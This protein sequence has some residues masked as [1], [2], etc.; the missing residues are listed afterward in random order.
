MAYYVLLTQ[1]GNK[2]YYRKGNLFFF[3]T[4]SKTGKRISAAKQIKARDLVNKLIKQI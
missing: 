3:R 1:I 2:K 4:V